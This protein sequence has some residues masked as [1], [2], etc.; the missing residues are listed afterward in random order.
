[1]AKRLL[2]KEVNQKLNEKIKEK[3]K[4]LKAREITP[5][6]AIIRIGNNP[7]DVSYEKGAAKRC[8]T[9]GVNCVKLLLPSDVG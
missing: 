2:G 1:M 6:L 4:I 9:L 7:G 3:V 5:T 8:Q